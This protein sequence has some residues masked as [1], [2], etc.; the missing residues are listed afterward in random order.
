MNI[1]QKSTHMRV[2]AIIHFQHD[3][4]RFVFGN[5]MANQR[6]L[7]VAESKCPFTRIIKPANA[8]IDPH[9]DAVACLVASRMVHV[10]DIR[11]VKV[12]HQAIIIQANL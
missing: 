7:G 12:M 8:A 1:A 4:H 5:R 3:L 6:I 9:A 11:V 2:D 10:P